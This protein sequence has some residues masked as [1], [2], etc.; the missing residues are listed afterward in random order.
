[1]TKST[2]PDPSIFTSLVMTGLAGFGPTG[3]FD[4]VLQE[5]TLI[6]A[7]RA[8]S[9]H[10]AIFN[11]EANKP[12]EVFFVGS[13]ALDAG[14]VDE[15]TAVVGIRWL[16]PICARRPRISSIASVGSKLI[17]PHSAATSALSFMRSNASNTASA[18][19]R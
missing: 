13:A 19:F 12:D 14:L 7:L 3:V 15:G 4:H 17:H 2:F 18:I 9:D 10:I 1:M 16:G 8:N 5:V 6:K 11:A